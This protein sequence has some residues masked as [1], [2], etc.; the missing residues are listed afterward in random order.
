M[1]CHVLSHQE[2]TSDLGPRSPPLP[3]SALGLRIRTQFL[4]FTAARRP[5]MAEVVNLLRPGNRK[6]LALPKDARTSRARSATPTLAGP[7]WAFAAVFAPRSA[8]RCADQA[9]SLTLALAVLD[10]KSSRPQGAV[11]H[12]IALARAPVF[13]VFKPL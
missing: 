6:M 7:H 11:L 4:D 10:G 3:V 9:G 13:K 2:M 5:K 12:E 1:C 8:P